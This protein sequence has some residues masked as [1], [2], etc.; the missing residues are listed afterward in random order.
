MNNVMRL[1]FNTNTPLWRYCLLMF[2]LASLPAIVIVGA[3]RFGLTLANA[4]F[5]SISPPEPDPSL[6][7]AIGAIIISPIVETYL[8]ALLIHLLCAFIG[9]KLRAAALSGILWGIG[10]ALFG[11]L[12][13]FGPAWIFF[14]FSCAYIAWHEKSFKH[15]YI[16]AC[17]PHVLNNAVLIAISSLR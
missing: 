16:A 9:N 3:V 8:L 10:H 2:A 5:A 13:F 15:A 6:V 11:V 14:I 4:E 17:V 12:W 7:G 1:L